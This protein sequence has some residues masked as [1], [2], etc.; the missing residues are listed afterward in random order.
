MTSPEPNITEIRSLIQHD[1]LAS[2]DLAARIT[3]LRH[4]IA[5]GKQHPVNG[6]NIMEI[7][8]RDRTKHLVARIASIE[9]QDP[10]SRTDRELLQ[11]LNARLAVCDGLAMRLAEL[12]DLEIE[13]RG[14]RQMAFLGSDPDA[15][16]KVVEPTTDVP[17][18]RPGL[19]GVSSLVDDLKR[20]S[21]AGEEYVQESGASENGEEDADDDEVD[22]SASW[23]LLYRILDIDP[24]TSSD[25][26]KQACD[27]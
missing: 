6:T 10:M 2:N 23:P 17:A 15:G 27:R 1:L 26:M 14:E 18:Y 12:R 7:S 25:S 8:N 19:S 16:V 22:T 11:A 5:A 24:K 4:D 13:A 21:I 20:L 9:S 3:Q